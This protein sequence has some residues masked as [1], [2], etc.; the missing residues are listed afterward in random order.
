MGDKK[1]PMLKGGGVAFGPH[2]RSFA[3]GAAG[4]GL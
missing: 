1:S 2:P 4:E 3:T